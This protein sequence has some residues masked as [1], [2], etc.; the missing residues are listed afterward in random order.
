LQKLEI[1]SSRDVNNRMSATSETSV[2]AGAPRKSRDSC[3]TRDNGNNRDASNSRYTNINRNTRDASNNMGNRKVNRNSKDKRNI[4]N[5]NTTRAPATAWMQAT[6]DLLN[7][8]Q[9]LVNIC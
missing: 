9:I 4:K 6:H 3:N 7:N 8:L 5:V 2:K 1:C